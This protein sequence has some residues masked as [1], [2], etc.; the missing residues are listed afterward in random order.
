MRRLGEPWSR[1]RCPAQ[2]PGH[3]DRHHYARHH[4]AS[5]YH[6]GHYDAGHY[7]AEHDGP[8]G[9]CGRWPGANVRADSKR[10]GLRVLP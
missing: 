4:Y 6:A 10:L 3:A 5:L 1:R 8:V 7:D 9:R 2:L